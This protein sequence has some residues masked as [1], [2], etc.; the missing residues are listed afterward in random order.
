MVSNVHEVLL[1][2]VH[3]FRSI[4]VTGPQRSGTTFMGKAISYD[5]ERVYVDEATFAWHNR[6][7]WEDIVSK[8]LNSV[9]Q[10]PTMMRYIHDVPDDVMVVV[11]RR[12]IEDI[13]ASQERIGWNDEKVELRKYGKSQGIVAQVK[14]DWWNK[15]K[16]FGPK[17]WV[18]VNYED[19]SGHP[20]WVEKEDR[21]DFD[22]K[23]TEI[24]GDE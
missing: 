6:E 18:E 16:H 15:H 5:T 23:Q 13:L 3:R 14:Y 9:I 10:C 17:H 2:D 20:L 24:K 21:K 4:V 22:S 1:P 8:S 11:M 12:S 19:M 7:L